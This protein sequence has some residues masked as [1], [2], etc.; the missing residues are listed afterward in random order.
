MSMY[1]RV[2]NARYISPN[3]SVWSKISGKTNKSVRPFRTKAKKLCSAC[4]REK[5]PGNHK[6]VTLIFGTL[7]YSAQDKIQAIKIII[8]QTLL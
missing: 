5:L 2:P 1:S 3:N 6:S 7:E 4:L 8:W